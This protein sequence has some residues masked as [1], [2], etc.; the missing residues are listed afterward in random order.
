MTPGFPNC[1]CFVC[2]LSVHTNTHMHQH[3]AEKHA[4]RK[5]IHGLNV[6][7]NEPPAALFIF[8]HT[9]T[10]DLG[11][12]VTSFSTVCTV[13]FNYQRSHIIIPA[14][15]C[16][17]SLLSHRP[18]QRGS[19][20]PLDSTEDLP[21]AASFPPPIRPKGVPPPFTF[22]CGRAEWESQKPSGRCRRWGVRS[23][24]PSSIP[25][26]GSN[27]PP[28]WFS[29]TGGSMRVLLVVVPHQSPWP[30]ASR[31]Q[32][33]PRDAG[34]PRR[35]VPCPRPPAARPPRQPH[36]PPTAPQVLLPGAATQAAQPLTRSAPS[37][38]SEV[39]L[40]VVSGHER[41]GKNGC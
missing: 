9:H 34:L 33:G 14:L 4:C 22:F 13:S 17:E 38:A 29:C 18:C 35:A 24:H 10:Y 27:P 40:K 12:H 26:G 25:D 7:I 39:G 3:I 5:F 36:L 41:E 6:C 32:A 15:F 37:A 28:A 2:G 21:P 11:A 1:I 30:P 19:C 20:G 23:P 31:R 16:L 8:A